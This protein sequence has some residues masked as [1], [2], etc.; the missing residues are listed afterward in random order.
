[1]IDRYKLEANVK[2]GHVAIIEEINSLEGDWVKHKDYIKE[3]DSISHEDVLGEVIKALTN[4]NSC[5]I[6]APSLDYYVDDHLIA[7]QI[8]NNSQLIN[9]L[10][11]RL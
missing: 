1:M 10:K 9:K 4:S 7:H 6:K 8:E 5:L 2:W 11:K 3:A